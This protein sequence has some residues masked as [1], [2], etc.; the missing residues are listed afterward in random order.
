LLV[1]YGRG[2]RI[3]GE[4]ET[5]EMMRNV[6]RAYAEAGA[7][8]RFKWLVHDKGHSFHGEMRETAFDWLSRWLGRE[9]RK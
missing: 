2:D 7:Q 9:Q 8:D 3:Y 5:V 4:P 6:E 1:L